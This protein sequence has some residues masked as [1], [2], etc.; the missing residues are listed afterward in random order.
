MTA[1]PF[2]TDFFRRQDE[3]PDDEFYELPRLVVHI[4][5]EAIEAVG[6]Y[7]GEVLPSGGVVLDLMSSWRSHLPT[8]TSVAKSSASV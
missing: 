8:A 5:D 3:S 7:L 1:S 6:V 4:D 2:P